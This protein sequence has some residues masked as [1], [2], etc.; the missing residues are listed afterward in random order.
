MQNPSSFDPNLLPVGVRYLGEISGV[1]NLP[2]N[3]MMG[4]VVYIRDQ[5]S[6]FLWS[7]RHWE[8]LKLH[9][10]AP[11]I[12]TGLNGSFYTQQ[13]PPTYVATGERM[14][15]QNKLTYKG[16]SYTIES[17]NNIAE[18][19]FR[20]HDLTREDMAFF[21]MTYPEE[22]KEFREGWARKWAI[23]RAK[24]EFDEWEE[25]PYEKK[26]RRNYP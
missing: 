19:F 26:R 9:Q 14:A 7:G 4:D 22:F 20:Q 21:K 12:M 25:D 24:E 1:T 18:L 2:S 5:Y 6:P 15:I 10:P 13:S 11:Q 3:P 23:E 8:A 16:I 17:Y